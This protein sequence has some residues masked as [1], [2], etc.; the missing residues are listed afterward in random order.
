MAP[1]TTSSALHLAWSVALHTFSQPKKQLILWKDRQQFCWVSGPQI[2]DSS[3]SQASQENT[4]VPH[5][6]S[7]AT[8]QHY[9]AISF[10][11]KAESRHVSQS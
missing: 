11:I 3:L 2:E 9:P 4:P 5:A 7:A 1:P 8:Q 6:L 10:G